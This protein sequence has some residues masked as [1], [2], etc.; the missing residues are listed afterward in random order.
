MAL[1]NIAF[2]GLG[3]MGRPMAA[4][5]ARAGGALSVWAR[6]AAVRDAVAAELGARAAASPAEAARDADFCFTMVSDTR[7]VE[8]VTLGPDGLAHGARP[9][10]VV[11]DTSTI[12]PS[13][14]RRVAAELGAREVAFLDAP[15]SGG[16]Q[17]AVAGTLSIMAG[18][19]AAVFQRALPLLEVLGKQITHIGASGAGQ[20][21]K[22]CNQ[23]VAAQTVAA[24]AEAFAF[25]RA[26]G[27]DP[28][29]VREALLGGFARSRVLELH[30]QRILDDDYAPGFKAS[31]H[32]KDMNIVA[33]EARA[34]GVHLPGADA[35][36]EL[37]DALV[38][39][40]GGERDSAALAEI[41]LRRARGD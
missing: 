2:I 13:G 24:V 25:A 3:I 10:S 34:A 41:V 9:G 33:D 12:A 18:G 11:I 15:V 14:A 28:A 16:E 22:A 31:L 32:L 40:G 30:G 20:V 7:A 36:R 17:G 26:A 37:L 39:G 19:D 1:G 27:A 6:R 29:R 21:A 8:E 4:N 5:L 38:T 23:L 35:A